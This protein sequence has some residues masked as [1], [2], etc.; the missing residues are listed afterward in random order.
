MKTCAHKHDTHWLRDKKERAVLSFFLLTSNEHGTFSSPGRC[1]ISIQ[2]EGLEREGKERP[3]EKESAG[4]QAFPRITATL[5]GTAQ[6]TTTKQPPC[7]RGG[8]SGQP[9]SRPWEQ[10]RALLSLKGEQLDLFP[11]FD[12]S[13]PGNATKESAC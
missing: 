5:R 2:R 9:L 13:V 12:V 7:S 3:N 10:Q 4:K 11:A 8:T 6:F 1:E